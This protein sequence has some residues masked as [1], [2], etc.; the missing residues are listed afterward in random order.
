VRAIALDGHDGA[1]KTTLAK[2]VAQR[3]GAVY[4]RPFAPPLGDALMAAYRAGDEPRVVEIGR[5]AIAAALASHSGR[6]VLDRGWLTVQT[7]LSG[8][9]E[10][11]WSDECRTVLCHCGID[12]TLRRLRARD[13]DTE[14]REWHEAF[15]SLYLE[16][17]REFK[18]E[19]V[20]T[21]RD[22]EEAARQIAGLWMEMPGTS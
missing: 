15:I 20:S 6:L 11:A 19:V 9:H 3:C 21:E 14:P 4:V 8:S 2:L 16:R 18:V 7:L 1:G 10:R 22:V 12:E 17:A 5:S 13:G